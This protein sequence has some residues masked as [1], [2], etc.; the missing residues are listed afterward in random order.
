MPGPVP[1]SLPVT[2]GNLEPEFPV[3]LTNR[4]EVP[5][6]QRVLTPATATCLLKGLQGWLPSPH[7]YTPVAY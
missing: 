1:G 7:L 4:G 3:S 6:P 5:T 2:L